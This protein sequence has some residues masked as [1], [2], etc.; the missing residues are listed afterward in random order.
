MFINLYLASRGPSIFLDKSGRLKEC[1]VTRQR[2]VTILEPL[3]N[4]V[5]KNQRFFL[6][7]PLERI[8][9]NDLFSIYF[10]RNIAATIRAQQMY[11][12]TALAYTIWVK[13]SFKVI[14]KGPTKG[15]YLE[16]WKIDSV[17]LYQVYLLNYHNCF[18]ICE[19]L[20]LR[21]STQRHTLTRDWNMILNSCGE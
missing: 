1:C 13:L 5:S 18:Y 21:A 2:S 3:T 8:S 17:F 16:V 9:R 11:R 19:G 6:H 4:W 7:S 12:P 20:Y 10:S 14:K 15:F